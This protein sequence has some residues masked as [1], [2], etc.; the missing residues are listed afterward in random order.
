MKV[1]DMNAR[2]IL[3]APLALGLS[4]GLAACDEEPEQAPAPKIDDKDRGAV[5]E[6]LGGTI[7]DEMIRYEDIQSRA[8]TM[9][10]APED[11]GSDGDSDGE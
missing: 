10:D 2:S 6:V 3:F 5:G 1:F 11:G 4:L 9:K 7:S 8:P